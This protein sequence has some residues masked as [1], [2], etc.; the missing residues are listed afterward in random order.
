MEV[1]FINKDLATEAFDKG[2]KQYDDRQ[3]QEEADFENR[4]QRD[5]AAGVDKALRTGIG[6]IYAKGATPTEAA[7]ATN[8]MP[9][10]VAPE[11]GTMPKMPVT[12]N[13]IT[14]VQPRPASPRPQVDEGGLINT[15]AATPGGGAT[16]LALHGSNVASQQ[17]A[18]DERRADRDKGSELYTKAMATGDWDT[19]KMIATQYA[20]NIPQQL[21]TDKNFML[22][23]TRLASFA[24]SKGLTGEHLVAFMHGAMT[25]TGTPE[26]RMQAGWKSAAGTL[27]KTVET[28]GGIMSVDASGVPTP[29]MGKDGKPLMPAIKT[30]VHVNSGGGEKDTA[31]IRNAKYLVKIGAAKD[32]NEAWGMVRQ[33]KTDPNAE[34]KIARNLMSSAKDKIGRPIYKTLDEAL[35]AVR[36]GAADD[37]APAGEPGAAPAIPKP[38]AGKAQRI[39]IGADGR[40]DQT[41]LQ[42]GATYTFKTKDGKDATGK[43]DATQKRFL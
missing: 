15:M 21:M 4:R 17:K 41:K 23:Q 12:A 9:A 22:D 36:K 1:N 24:H 7:P 11:P 35:A 34:V 14:S 38:S 42:N 30:S 39:P 10:I 13:P 33:V 31:D 43:W 3:R 8:P 19:A 16:A 37:G 6:K 29:M 25:A 20:L 28:S 5:Q 27:K 2:Q 32:E 40:P 26:E 18:H